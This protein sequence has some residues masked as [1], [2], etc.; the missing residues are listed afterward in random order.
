M[1]AMDMD[2]DSCLSAQIEQY[3]GRATRWQANWLTEE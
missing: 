3:M 1:I 2:A